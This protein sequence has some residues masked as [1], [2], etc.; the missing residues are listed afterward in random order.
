MNQE[1]PPRTSVN[2][3]SYANSENLEKLEVLGSGISAKTYLDGSRSEGLAVKVGHN[4]Q[5][6]PGADSEY[7]I[8]RLLQLRGDKLS[9]EPVSFD[10]DNNILITKAIEGE[11][12]DELTDNDIKNMAL[13]IGKFHSR[14]MSR[15]GKPFT[16]RDKITQFE[17]LQKQ[18]KTVEP[19]LEEVKQIATLEIPNSNIPPTDTLEAVLNKIK[20]LSEDYR[21]FF[22]E[23]SFSLIHYDMNPSNLLKTKDGNFFILDWRNSSVG[24]RALDLAKFF[25]KNYLDVRKQEIFMESYL[26]AVPDTT[27]KERTSVYYPLVRLISVLWRLEH[28][29]VDI[30]NNPKLEESI[31]TN[32]V[33]SRLHDD[34]IYLQEFCKENEK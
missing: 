19:W 22:Q 24:D 9:P 29:Y 33:R 20:A 4:P 12:I 28:L 16:E 34:F 8:L 21:E 17:Q 13:V 32:L 2:A 1:I 7:A 31:D 10:K 15:P 25:Y 30:R 5:E 11:K 18:I 26:E 23:S 14:E 6:Y 27:I 3:V